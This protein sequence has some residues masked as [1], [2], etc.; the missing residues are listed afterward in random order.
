MEVSVGGGGV[1]GGRS[2]YL[3]RGRPKDE[4]LEEARC[5]R[6]A[7]FTSQQ[8]SSSALQVG[9]WRALPSPSWL[10]SGRGGCGKSLRNPPR[11]QNNGIGSGEISKMNLNRSATLSLVRRQSSHQLKY[12]GHHGN[13]H[14]VRPTP[15][16]PDTYI[17]KCRSRLLRSTHQ[18]YFPGGK[19]ESQCCSP[20]SR[21]CQVQSIYTRDGR[22]GWTCSS[23]GCWA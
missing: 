16:S 17:V 12:L 19:P 4:P 20:W 2:L 23:A 5:G 14:M 22:A 1:P 21:G 13:S 3:G 6:R 10:C 15:R 11:K 9:I 8:A 18:H 7:H